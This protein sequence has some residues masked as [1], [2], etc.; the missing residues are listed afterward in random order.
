[1]CWGRPLEA[2]AYVEEAITYAGQHEVHTLAEYARTMLAWLR[3]RGG[4]WDEAE[5]V[6]ARVVS[7]GESIPQLLARTVLTE[8]AIRRGDPDAAGDLAGLAA[9]AE[10][11]GE[12]QRLAP[13][14]ELQVESALLG[15]SPMPCRRIEELVEEIRR[16]RGD[17][18]GWGAVRIAVTA[19]LVGIDVD[20]K[21]PGSPPLDAMLRRDWRAAA[22][23]YG[24]VG[25]GYDRALM[26]S[27][28][29]DADSLAEA[30]G[31]ARELGA[32]PLARR[33][34]ERMR[35]LGAAVP[36]G[37]RASTR[38]NPA[39]LTG[40]QLE[41]LSL[42]AGGLSNAEI[43][44]RL[45]VSPRTA[46]HHVAAVIAK[47]GAASRWDA[48]RRA[49]ELELV[50]TA[51]RLKAQARPRARTT[52]RSPAPPA[53]RLLLELLRAQLEERDEVRRRPERIGDELAAAE[54]QR[55]DDCARRPRRRRS[56]W[57]ARARRRARRAAR[58]P[59]ASPTVVSRR[60]TA[61]FAGTGR[62]TAGAGCTWKASW[63]ARSSSRS[64]R[65][66]HR[67]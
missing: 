24:A 58:L 22:D 12:L 62:V 57:P 14:V 20:V 2:R 33:V 61:S 32:E 63:T 37:P 42:L 40:R 64:V 4:E 29:D 35:D 51:A 16:V 13:V 46:E 6:A 3:L 52:P 23:A 45:V 49:A 21:A 8:L 9:Q 65:S 7:G 28:L 53:L 44:D 1:M 26:L 54:R 50:P 15:G 60:S 59:S 18:S 19:S 55:R 47:L 36:R 39:G 5:R 48:V 31:I 27:L 34:A 56:G 11:T 30:I 43:A 67:L 38:A 41:V 25:W 10:R 66:H 17:F